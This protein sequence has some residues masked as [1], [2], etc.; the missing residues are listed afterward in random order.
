MSKKPKPLSPIWPNAGITAAYRRALRDL[1]EEMSD[2]YEATLAAQ[3]EERPPALA[4][5]RRTWTDKAP[6]EIRDAVCELIALATGDDPLREEDI[7]RL[8]PLASDATP[9]RDLEREL[10]ALGSRWEKRFNAAAPQLAKWF[11]AKVGRRSDAALRKILRDAGI[12]VR[13]QMTPAM[14]D[15]VDAVVQENVGLIKSIATQHHGEVQGL[16]MRSVAAGRDLSGL[17]RELRARYGVTQR[18][19]ELIARDQN[20]KATAALRRVREIDLG[21]E[22]GIW[23]HS[24][25]GKE[26]RPTHVKNHGKKFNLREGWFDPD[27]RVRA[28]ILPGTLIN[29]RCTWRPVVKGFS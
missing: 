12:T 23:L 29:C 20:S 18:R 11:Q 24:A 10:R 21:I 8:L 14:R 1:I 25:A 26:P 28:R 22:Q 4:T 15:V 19:A 5:D 17:S 9:A 13:Y 3:Y 27:P 6:A 16:V 2:D 7:A